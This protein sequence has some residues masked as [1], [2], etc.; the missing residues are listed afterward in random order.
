MPSARYG[1]ALHAEIDAL[2]GAAHA[3]NAKPLNTPAVAR[4]VAAEP[5]GTTSRTTTAAR[6]PRPLTCGT[7]PQGCLEALKACQLGEQ[8]VGLVA[9][10]VVRDPGPQQLLRQARAERDAVPVVRVPDAVAPLA[11]AV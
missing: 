2:D 4:A 6:T 11:Q 9:R 8:P 1:D 10:V 5:V 7:M 3:S